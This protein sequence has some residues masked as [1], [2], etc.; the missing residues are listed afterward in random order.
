[1]TSQRRSPHPPG[2][3]GSLSS[4]LRLRPPRNRGGVRS[5]RSARSAA[6]SAAFSAARSAFSAYKRGKKKQEA[7][8]GTGPCLLCVCASRHVRACTY[9]CLCKGARVQ[10]LPPSQAAQWALPLG[11]MG[12]MGCTMGAT[13]VAGSA[14]LVVPSAAPHPS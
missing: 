14:L 12:T 8:V 7:W 11:A 10:G 13:Q 1:V 6:F 9:A 2:M 4:L 3:R 5:A